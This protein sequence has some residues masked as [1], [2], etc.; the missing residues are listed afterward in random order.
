MFYSQSVLMTI[1]DR[2]LMD[3]VARDII[4]QAV[5]KMFWLLSA[6]FMSDQASQYVWLKESRAGITTTPE[7]VR[8]REKLEI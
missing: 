3:K 7:E 1:L 2:L 8:G 4:S 5:K 6:I